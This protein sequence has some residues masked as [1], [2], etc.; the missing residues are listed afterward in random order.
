[1]NDAGGGIADKRRRRRDLRHLIFFS[2]TLL[3]ERERFTHAHWLP[4]SRRL[5]TNPKFC[6]VDRTNEAK[7][8]RGQF[9][10]GVTNQ[11]FNRN[12]GSKFK[13]IVTVFQFE[14]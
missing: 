9:E 1:M 6:R 10:S 8:R 14:N 2:N 3:Q 11:E 5:S 12:G 4:N 7:R 13:K